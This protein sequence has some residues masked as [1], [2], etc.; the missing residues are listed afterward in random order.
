[1]Y[2]SILKKKKDKEKQEKGKEKTAPKL[3]LHHSLQKETVPSTA[4]THTRIFMYVF[5][6]PFSWSVFDIVLIAYSFVLGLE[7]S[8][9]DKRRRHCGN[10][11]SQ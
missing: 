8:Y 7:P 9:L 1:M 5:A 6:S 3:V 10:S 4:P 11:F 2:H